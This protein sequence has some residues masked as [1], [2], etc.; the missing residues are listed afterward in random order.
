ALPGGGTQA[1]KILL[2]KRLFNTGTARWSLKGQGWGACQS[3][4]VDGLTDNVSWYFPRGPRQSTSLDGSFASKDPTD[5]RVFNWT[6]IFDEIA[7]FELNTRGVS[8]GVGAIVSKVSTPPAN[9]D[10][11]DIAKLGHASLGGSALAASSGSDVP[12]NFAGFAGA[13]D[14]WAAITEYVRH[15]RSPRRPTSLDAAKVASGKQLFSAGNCQGCHGGDKW[16]ISRLFY[17]PDKNVTNL[18]TNVNQ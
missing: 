13:R 6:A 17:T 7:D 1:E 10:R 18:A 3:C 11:I 16:T 8:G 2:G 5:Q 9:A 15:I 14:D 4:H 12:D